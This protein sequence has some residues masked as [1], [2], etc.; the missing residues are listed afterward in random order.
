VNITVVTPAAVS[1]TAPR[2]TNSFFSFNYN[3]DVGLRYAVERSTD[4]STW[5][6]L[7]TNIAS[8]TA[9]SFSEGTVASPPRMYRVN[10]LPNP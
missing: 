4:L 8:N 2:V 9:A 3:A 5:V 6:A 7:T 10:R 1:L